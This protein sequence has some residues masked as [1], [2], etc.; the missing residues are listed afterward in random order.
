MYDQTTDTVQQEYD[1]VII[2]SYWFQISE[3]SGE[4]RAKKYAKLA[5]VAQAALTLVRGNAAPEREFSVK[6]S[7]L[8]KECLHAATVREDYSCTAI[9]EGRY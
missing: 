9:S 1:T 7:V 3:I 8:G 2:R 4:A 5:C 6:Y